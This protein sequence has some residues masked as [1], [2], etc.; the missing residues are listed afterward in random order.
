MGRPPVPDGQKP[1]VEPHGVSPYN[2]RIMRMR[3]RAGRGFTDR[4]NRRGTRA[5][6]LTLTR[7]MKN[8]LFNISATDPATFALIALLL[9]GVALIASYIPARRATKVNPLMALHHE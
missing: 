7:V 5:G 2:F 4:D 8:L 1:Q 6:A 9:V 3:L